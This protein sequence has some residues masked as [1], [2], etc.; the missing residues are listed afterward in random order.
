[1]LDKVEKNFNKEMNESK[2][3]RKKRWPGHLR[4]SSKGRSLTSRLDVMRGKDGAEVLLASAG[5]WSRRPGYGMEGVPAV[6][7]AWL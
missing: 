4:A 7:E 5:G 1:M 2:G 3:E 6:Q